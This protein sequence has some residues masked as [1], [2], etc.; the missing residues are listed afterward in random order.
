MSDRWS[1]LAVYPDPV[2]AEAFA[3]LLR[4][5]AIPV[6][7][8]ADEPVPGLM[9]AFSLQVPEIMLG[10]ARTICSQAPLSDDEWAQYVADVRAGEESGD[11][12]QER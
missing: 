8:E 9:R 11:N 6:R 10:R 1:V 7:I 3:G 5:E 12:D 4:S 2:S